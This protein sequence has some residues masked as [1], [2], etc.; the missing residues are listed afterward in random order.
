MKPNRSNIL[1]NQ[2]LIN[3]FID[4]NSLDILEKSILHYY[5]LD[6]CT[7]IGV[8]GQGMSSSLLRC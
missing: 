2:S 6:Y 4:I 7:W 8:Y 5:Q 1:C 3:S